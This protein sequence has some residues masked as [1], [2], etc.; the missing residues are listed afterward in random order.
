MTWIIV[1]FITE[2]GFEQYDVSN[3]TP[4]RRRGWFTKAMRAAGY[5]SYVPT[6]HTLLKFLLSGND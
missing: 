3:A 6:A 5:L 2:S 1:N 4:R